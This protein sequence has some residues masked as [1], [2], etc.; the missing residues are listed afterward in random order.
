LLILVCL[1]VTLLGFLFIRSLIDFPVYYAAGQSLLGGR[2]DLY[3]PDFALGRVMD[4]RY[5]PF[6]LVLFTPLWLVPYSTSAYIWYLLC[7]LEIAGSGIVIRRVFPSIA[8]SWKMWV[9]VALSTIQYFVMAIHYGN[10]HLLAIAVL[11]GSFYFVM[12][13]KDVIS[14]LLMAF[15]I[16]L[17]VTPVLLLPYFALKRRWK[18]LGMVGIFLVLLNLG[19]SIYFGFSNNNRLMANWYEHVITSQEFHE[20]N[21]PLNLSL[22]GELRRYLSSVDYSKRV[23]GDV[24]YPAINIASFSRENLVLVWIVLA[25]VV[26][27]LAMLLSVYAID[28]TRG[29]IEKNDRTSGRFAGEIALMVCLMLFVGP[30]TSKIYFVALLWPIAYLA[31]LAM[32]KGTREGQLATRVLVVVAGVNS[33]LP[34]LPGRSVQRLLLVLGIDFYLNCLV[35]ATVAFG[36]ISSYRVIR[37]RSGERLMRV[38]SAARTP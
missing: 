8:G 10:V 37:K 23:D 24:Q 16:T 30:L 7:A 32:K 12:S 25:G 34:L 36:M 28:R 21:G 14:G 19:P 31:S 11:F 18:M 6:F 33:V 5:L 26:F 1:S 13:G 35:M 29:N 2:T 38:Q 9:L 17:K 22:K 20:D 3:A 15:A 4:Y 27:L